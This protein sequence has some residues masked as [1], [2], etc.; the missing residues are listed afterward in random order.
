MI[1]KAKSKVADAVDNLVPTETRIILNLASRPPVQTQDMSTDLMHNILRAAEAGQ[2]EDYLA[3][4]RDITSGDAAVLSDWMQR[5]S[6]LLSKAWTLAAEVK[7]DPV[8]EGNAVWMTSQLRGCAGFLD[9]RAHLLDSTLFPVAVVEKIFAKSAGGYRLAKLVPVPHDLL[10][11][12]NG[13]LQ[14]KET[15]PDGVPTGRLLDLDPTR[16][17]MHRGHLLRGLPD[18]WGGPGRAL[19]FYWFLAA[20]GR[21]WW[22]RGL[23]RDGGPFLLG[24]YNP[25]RPEDR[26]AMEAAFAD[27]VQRFGLVVSNET[28]VEVFKDL[29]SGTAVAHQAYQTHMLSMCSRVVIGQTL[30]SQ[31][32]NTGLG[33]NQASV[34]NDVLTDVAAF[35]DMLLAE[36]LQEQ[37][38]IPLLQLNARPGPP[39]TFTHGV[40]SENLLSRATLLKELKQAGIK[41]RKDG[42]ATLSEIFS[43]PLEVETPAAAPAALATLSAQRPVDR[44][45]DQ[46]VRNAGATFAQAFR[47]SLAP[48][49]R[50]IEAS[51]S[52]EEL[53]R[54]LGEFY[55]D[56]QPGRLARLKAEA[57]TAFAAN[58]ALGFRV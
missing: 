53:E 29:A 16:Y 21:S 8:A 13:Y 34:Q 38:F 30:T 7:K 50:L 2:W 51:T 20:A 48:V 52:P 58:A 27:A 43:M 41:V 36:T 28:D 6:R 1:A 49:K 57:L 25:E 9:A 31:A 3:L 35:D 12:R 11:Y 45:N 23:E 4:L 18:C 10:S 54:Q 39:P 19:V 47:G 32:A 55:A 14:I 26:G 33:S 56:W 15:T 17:I 37:L 5:K 24:K 42:E 40:L 44:A 22:A 46:L